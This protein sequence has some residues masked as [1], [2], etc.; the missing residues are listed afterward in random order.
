MSFREKNQIPDLGVGIGARAK[1]YPDLFG[2]TDAKPHES[3]DWVEVISENFM[4]GGG[5]PHRNLARLIE[6]YRVVP[7]GVSMSIGAPGKV[8]LAYLTRLKEVVKKI[9]PPW[10]SDH[11][12]WTGAHGVE[13]HDLL[14]LPHTK[15]A[16]AHVSERIRQVQDFLEVPFAIE[17]VSSYLAYNS[18]EMPEWEFVAE[19]AEKA[20]CGILFDCNNIYVSGFNHGFDP[21][22]YVDAMPKGR[23]VQ[24]HLAGHTNKGKYLLDTHSDHVTD[25]VWDLYRRAT[26]R[27][28][29]VST[30]IE[31]DEDIPAFEVVAQEAVK[32]RAVRS[33]VLGLAKRSTEATPNEGAR[34]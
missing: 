13:I 15:E 10:C 1:H 30:L 17:N 32:A 14:P 8:D 20:D 6:K 22:D 7:H 5:R 26:E 27:F 23:V 9:D 18:S 34:T 24:M 28:G 25:P 31:W 3:I 21:N 29:A 16:I 19:I 2:E 11:L 33:Q 4:V 12:C